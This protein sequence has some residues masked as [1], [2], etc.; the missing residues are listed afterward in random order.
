VR[1]VYAADRSHHSRRQFTYGEGSLEAKV[2][3][4]RERMKISHVSVCVQCL[5]DAFQ[6]S[7]RQSAG[8]DSCETNSPPIT[9]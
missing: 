7:A 6:R 4:A 8:R 9:V 3:S 5:E 2:M 1:F